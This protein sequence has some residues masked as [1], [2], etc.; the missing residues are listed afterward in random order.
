MVDGHFHRKSLVVYVHIVPTAY[1]SEPFESE[2]RRVR[3]SIAEA[4]RFEFIK[5]N[6]I[7]KLLE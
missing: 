7:I 5:T 4:M 1:D 2:F 3:I 6:Y